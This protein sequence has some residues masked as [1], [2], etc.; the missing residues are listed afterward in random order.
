MVK[1]E[2]VLPEGV[3]KALQLVSKELGGTPSEWAAHYIRM[4]L[5]AEADRDFERRYVDL[6]EQVKELL[7]EAGV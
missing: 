3:W 4:E 5:E 7:K 1:V 6:S 2:L